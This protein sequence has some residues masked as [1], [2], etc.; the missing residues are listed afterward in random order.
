MIRSGLVNNRR[1]GGFE[2]GYPHQR[3]N[4]PRD[5]IVRPYV[6]GIDTGMGTRSDLKQIIPKPVS[7]NQIFGKKTTPDERLYLLRMVQKGMVSA[8]A[9][10]TG[11]PPVS[12]PPLPTQ[13]PTVVEEDTLPG[14]MMESED[15]E[16]SLEDTLVGEQVQEDML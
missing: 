13:A 1:G 5:E 14:L 11:M 9:T 12:P 3:D 10:K 8:S 15:E 7:Y 2:E 4:T 16:D 6:D